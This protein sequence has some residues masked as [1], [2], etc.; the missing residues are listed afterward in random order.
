[1]P[2]LPVLPI[3]LL[4]VARRRSRRSNPVESAAL[5]CFAALAMTERDNAYPEGLDFFPEKG[6][7]FTFIWDYDPRVLSHRGARSRAF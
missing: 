3:L 2:D 1:M 5:D 4:A 6:L 7:T